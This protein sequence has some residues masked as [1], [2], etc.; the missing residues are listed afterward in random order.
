M[1]TTFIADITIIIYECIIV[2][3]LIVCI[4]KMSKNKKKYMQNQIS[5]KNKKKQDYLDQQIKNNIRGD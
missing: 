2:I 1:I 4:L 5:K 3:S